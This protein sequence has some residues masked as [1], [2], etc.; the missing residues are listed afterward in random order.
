MI[1]FIRRTSV[2]VTIIFIFFFIILNSPVL[3]QE[4]AGA[5]FQELEK[6]EFVPPPTLETPVIETGEEVK[7]QIPSGP[8]ILIKKINLIVQNKK[9]QSLLSPKTIKA[10]TSK[11]ENRE[12]DLVEMNQ[13]SEEITASYHAEGYIIAYAFIPQQEIKEGVL[14]IGIIQGKTAEITV[15][16]NK[17]FSSD[18]IRNHLQMIQNDPSLKKNTLEKALLILN[19]YPSLNVKA[20]LQSGKEFGETDVTAQVKDSMPVSGSLTYDNFGSDV[21]SKSRLTAEFNIG[22]LLTSGDYF[23]FRGLTGLDRIDLQNLSYVRADYQVP[24]AYHG[25]K[26]GLYYSNSLNEAGE[27]YS[28]LDIH[29]KAHVAGVYVTHPLVRT[30]DTSLDVKFGFDYKDVYDY[31]LGEIRSQ[32]NIRVFNLGLT[33]NFVDNFSGRNIIN[34]TYDQGIRNI[35]GGNGDNDPGTSRLH[36]DGGFSKATLDLA[37]IQKLPGYNHFIFRASGLY[38]ND[39]L[40]VAEQFFLGGMGSVRGF[41]P[42]SE[43]GDRG[44]LLSGELYLAPPYPET[45]IFNQ[46]LGDTIKFVLFADHGGVFKN[47][48]QPGEDK[49]GYMTSI[50]AGLR[51]YAGKYFSARLDWAVPRIDDQFKTNHAET[52][53]Q[54]ALNF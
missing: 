27:E 26:V 23:M 14:E 37:R 46:N 16:G 10:I 45:K 38:S 5:V 50:G 42:S 19:E 18:F 12:L 20:S 52:Y 31:I 9:D 30:R 54:V 51:L 35:F 15:T 49:V 48:I 13:I 32:D 25:T 11:Y 43:S 21:T 39:D 3:A 1:F 2:V 4:K 47:D 29:G 24:V 41:K 36:A 40:F 6:K 28:I 22:N 17:S 8:K 53:V 44:Y 7:Q 33:Y 34:L